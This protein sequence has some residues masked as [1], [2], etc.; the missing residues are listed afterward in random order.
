MEM[1]S[2]AV[3]SPEPVRQAIIP[4]EYRAFQDVFSKRLATELPPHRPWDCAIELLPGAIMPKGHIYPL[5]ILEKKATEEYVTE[6]MQQDFIQPSTS[7]AASSFVGKKDRGL[8]PCIDYR[9]LNAHTKRLAYPLPLV[10]AVLEQLRHATIFSKLDLRSAYNLIRVKPGDEWKMAFITP[11]G[12]YEYKV[13]PFGLVNSP[14]IF[15]NLM[16]E[17]FRDLLGKFV[18][19][20]INDILIF[21]R[22]YKEQIQQVTDILKRLRRHHLYL[23]L[24]KCQF[25]RT[26][27]HFLGYVISHNTV[28]MDQRKE[29]KMAKADA[30]SRQHYLL[31]DTSTPSPILSPKVF[32]NPIIWKADEEIAGFRDSALPGGPEE[33]GVAAEPPPPPPL[34]PSQQVYRVESILD[35]R[36]T[37]TENRT[38]FIQDSSVSEVLSD[39]NENFSQ[40]IPAGPESTFTERLIVS[41]SDQSL[42]VY[43]GE[44]VTL[45]CSVDSHI[46]PEHFEEVSWKTDKDEHIT[47]LLYESNKIH[48]DSSDER[49]RDRV[50]FFSD[51]IHRGNFSL[52]LKR[53]RTEDKGL[54]MCHVFAGRFSDNTTIVLQ[55]PGEFKVI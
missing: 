10:P 26:T 48:P 28:R 25:H 27:I 20:Y 34:D 54:Y 43:V 37:D 17:I 50:E 36:R 3:E 22:S 45:N 7:P 33:P 2:T 5:S 18:I 4:H 32:I 12:H 29:L 41:G 44:D 24:E 23:K 51:E 35:S 38:T 31:P 13:M 8:R 39:E 55:Q 15:Q 11:T 14:A 46:P 9:T 53:V 1:N 6:T 49:Y 42:S 19:V 16:N 47:V 21:S 30:L 40:Q 52:R